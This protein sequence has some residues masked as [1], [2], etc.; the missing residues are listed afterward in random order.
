MNLR[1]KIIASEPM[2]RLGS[3]TWNTVT[4][5]VGNFGTRSHI[6]EDLIP[7]P[8][9]TLQRELTTLYPAF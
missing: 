6:T 4:R 1:L 9:P 8:L 3:Y 7:M 2:E 5:W